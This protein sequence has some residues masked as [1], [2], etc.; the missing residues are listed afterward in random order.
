MVSGHIADKLGHRKLLVRVGYGVTP[1]GQALIALWA[2]MG[3]PTLTLTMTLSMGVLG[4][5][6]GSAKFFSSATV[7]V[8]WTTASP[9]VAFALAAAF[10]GAG[11]LAM[12]RA[13]DSWTA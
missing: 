6:N 2:T 4:T 3:R 5:V 12:L 10:M 1:P 8:V 13:R 11:T 7:G 9:A